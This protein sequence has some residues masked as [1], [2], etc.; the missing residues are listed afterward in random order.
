MISRRSRT[1]ALAVAIVGAVLLGG[2]NPAEAG[3]R[4]TVSSN[5]DTKYFFSG[6]SNDN[7]FSTA[8]ILPTGFVV[9]VYRLAVETSTTN[10]GGTAILGRINTTVTVDSLDAIPTG[11]LVVTVDV[12]VDVVGVATGEVT[13]LA[14]QGT[15]AGAG[16]KSFVLPDTDPLLVSSDS[17][18]DEGMTSPDDATVV[19]TTT[20]EGTAVVSNA[21]TY[22][23]DDS[24]A[25]VQSV[26]NPNPPS[27]YTYSQEVR[28]SGVTNL[29]M[30]FQFTGTSEV[31]PTAIPEPGTVAMALSGLPLFGFLALRRW[32]RRAQA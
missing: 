31:N 25:N 14:Q 26:S 17:G 4:I 30:N 10:F 19:T 20:V 27:G 3:L 13:D 29:A 24:P 23:D 1:C 12:I 15:L 5:G 7:G 21:F 8:G 18:G 22:P 32:R 11:D 28:L 16:L 2:E 9:D 6:N